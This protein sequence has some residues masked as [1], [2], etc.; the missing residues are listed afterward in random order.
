MSNWSFKASFVILALVLL[1]PFT[2][3]AAPA[4]PEPTNAFYVNDFANVID[5]ADELLMIENGKEL[6]HLNGA[7]IVI[8]T[9]DFVGTRSISDYAAELFNKWG[10]GDAK[11]N[12][13]LLILLSIG[14]D[15]YWAVQGRGL[16]STL[17]SGTISNILFDYLEEDF[18]NKRYSAGAT[19]VYS[20]FVQQLGGTWA[21]SISTDEPANHNGPLAG[22]E[23][24]ANASDSEET[25]PVMGTYLLIHFICAL[26]V[27]LY[28]FINRKPRRFPGK[29]GPYT[30]MPMGQPELYSSP[31]YRSRGSM[32]NG[33]GQ[34]ANYHSRTTRITVEEQELWTSPTYDYNRDVSFGQR[35][36]RNPYVDEPNPPVSSSIFKTQ[37]SSDKGN[38]WFKRIFGNRSRSSYN[39]GGGGYTSGGGAGRTSN[40]FD[41]SSS[42]STSSW[43]SSSWGSSGWGSSNSDSSSS[44]GGGGS[45]RGGGAG[46]R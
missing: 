41:S 1:L 6:N 22:T 27:L 40:Y 28:L 26:N 12:N 21:N 11:K 16:E 4:L 38:R 25:F 8:V 7:Q 33:F 15:N 36:Y 10:I 35:A 37:D 9:V 46:R 5:P 23:E 19:K 2:V 43:G 24:L 44:S 20:G 45:T 30:S 42:N 18:A 13:G 17:T 39:S 3:Y 34:Q 14:D 29:F 32:G 31:T